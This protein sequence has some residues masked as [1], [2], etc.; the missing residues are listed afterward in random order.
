MSTFYSGNA[1]FLVYTNLGIDD[2][3]VVMQWNSASLPLTTRVT[4]MKEGGTKAAAFFYDQ[5]SGTSLF[6][7]SNS[8]QSTVTVFVWSVV[9]AEFYETTPFFTSNSLSSTPGLVF[10]TLQG[11]TYLA[12]PSFQN[13]VTDLTSF[14]AIY[15]FSLDDGFSQV[16][17]YSPNLQ[18]HA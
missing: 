1:Q 8:V 12:V 16:R 11:S 7:V 18:T 15:V 13:T 14:M 17:V 6:A 2:S 5:V 9:N 4:F 10:F 3:S